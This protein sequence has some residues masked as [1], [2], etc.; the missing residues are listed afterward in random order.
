MLHGALATF[1]SMD[2]RSYA[3][4]KTLTIAI[5][6][7]AVSAYTISASNIFFSRIKTR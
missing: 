2:I 6:T 1:I 5:T 7:F 3:K 4:V